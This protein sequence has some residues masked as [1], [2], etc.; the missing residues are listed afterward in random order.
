MD[1]KTSAVTIYNRSRCLRRTYRPNLRDK[2]ST[3]GAIAVW[4]RSSLTNGSSNCFPS[5]LLGSPESAEKSV[6][7]VLTYLSDV[8]E[9]L[10][11]TFIGRNYNLTESPTAKKEWHR[12]ILL[13]FVQCGIFR[14]GFVGRAQM[15]RLNEDRSQI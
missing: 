1:Y 6:R 2:S 4:C 12:A 8:F 14:I 13:S 11:L 10:V 3:G 5:I 9:V 7:I 15:E